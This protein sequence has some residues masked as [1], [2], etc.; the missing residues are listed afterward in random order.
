MQSAANAIYALCPKSIG[1]R[2]NITVFDELDSTNTYLKHLALSHAEEGTVI[3]ARR[4]SAGRGRLGRSF[5]SPDMTG[6]YISVLLRPR[7]RAENAVNVTAMTAVAMAHAIERV[8]PAKAQI[9]WVND[10]FVEN[11]K[12]C[13]IL[14]ESK[15]DINA[16]SEY[17][18]VGAGVNV[19][20]P[21]GGFPKEIEGIAGAL[22][23][24]CDVEHKCNE[25]AAA[26]IEE[27]FTGYE[28][29]ESKGFLEEYRRRSLAVN[30]RIAILS[31]GNVKEAKAIGIDDECRLIVHHD[32]GEVEHIATGE[33]SIKLL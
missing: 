31:G 1:K 6:L 3:I 15:F 5:F 29:L 22:Y 32:N 26:F 12:V 11:K 19:C 21:R 24:D 18:V 16:V 17:V 25:L 23:G 10:I 30:K 20:A 14:C 27:L 2:V 13:G 28:N 7:L 33:I 9:K 8:S 4:Q